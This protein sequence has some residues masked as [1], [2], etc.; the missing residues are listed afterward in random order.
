VLVS[1]P[2]YNDSKLATDQAPWCRP[3]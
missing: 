2:I 3:R 1:K